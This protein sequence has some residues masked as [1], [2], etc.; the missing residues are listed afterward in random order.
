[1]IEMIIFFKNE[2]DKEIC[3]TCFFEIRFIKLFKYF[4]FFIK[5]VNNDTINKKREMS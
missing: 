1:M 4:S 2:V 5:N 3:Y